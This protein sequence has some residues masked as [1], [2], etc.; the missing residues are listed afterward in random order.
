LNFQSP[1]ITLQSHVDPSD[2]AT[3]TATFGFTRNISI[4]RHRRGGLPEFYA[5]FKGASV[6]A[7]VNLVASLLVDQ[8][9]AVRAAY[10]ASLRSM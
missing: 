9:H 6:D 2:F 3:V 5:K 10:I 4:R 7:S 1:W 8:Q